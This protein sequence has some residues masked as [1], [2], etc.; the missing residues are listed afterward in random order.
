[1]AYLELYAAQRTPVMEA[2]HALDEQ[3]PLKLYDCLVPMLKEHRRFKINLS[4]KFSIADFK[5]I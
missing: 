2:E 1:M 3:T 4:D 5:T